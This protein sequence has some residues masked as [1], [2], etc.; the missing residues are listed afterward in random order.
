MRE[1]QRE[2]DEGYTRRFGVEV[3]RVEKEVLAREA[4]VLIVLCSLNEDTKGM[5]NE[6]FLNL[7]KRDSVLINVAR[8]SRLLRMCN[9]A[10]ILVKGANRR[11][12]WPR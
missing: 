10:D 2:I 9:D 5:V 7:M 12:G 4:D 11:F 3:R 6:E 8:V 1:D